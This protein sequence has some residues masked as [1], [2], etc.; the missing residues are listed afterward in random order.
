MSW[1][2]AVFSGKFKANSL[3]S[4]TFVSIGN[5]CPTK[6]SS[7]VTV[8]DG[9]ATFDA[10]P[11]DST[12]INSAGRC[13]VDRSLNEPPLELVYSEEN[14]LHLHTGQMVFDATCGAAV[15]C[16]G[17]GNQEVIEAI[18]Y[19]LAINTYSNSMRFTTAVA[20]EL[21]DEIILGTDNLMSRVYICSSGTTSSSSVLCT[22]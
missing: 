9:T 15:A 17:H 20:T 13:L 4:N 6:S 16:L 11:M 3:N 18:T 21:A 12:Q 10:K 19:Q 2:A 7:K 22:G 1:C 5:K 8:K 14:Y